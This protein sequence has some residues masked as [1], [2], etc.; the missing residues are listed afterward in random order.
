MFVLKPSAVVHNFLSKILNTG[1]TSLCLVCILMLPHVFGTTFVKQTF[2]YHVILKIE[3]VL[4]LKM[5]MWRIEEASISH[6]VCILC[7]PEVFGRTFVK[8]TSLYYVIL[9]VKVQGVLLLRI[10]LWKKLPYII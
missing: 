6:L 3:G 4:L 9:L 1:S 10:D 8:E 2:L 5:D 7:I